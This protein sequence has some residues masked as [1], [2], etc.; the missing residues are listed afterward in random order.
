MRQCNLQQKDMHLGIHVYLGNIFCKSN[1]LRRYRTDLEISL[2]LILQG[3]IAWL[4][5]MRIFSAL[6]MLTNSYIL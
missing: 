1:I 2:E 3:V 5:F 6:N 4:D